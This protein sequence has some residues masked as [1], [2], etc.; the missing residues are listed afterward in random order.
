ME[1]LAYPTMVIMLQYI[2]IS[3]QHTVHPKVIQHYMLMYFIKVGKYFF[4]TLK[5]T[6][7]DHLFSSYNSLTTF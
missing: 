1:V 6:A 7:A 2:T 5:I 3:S 4:N